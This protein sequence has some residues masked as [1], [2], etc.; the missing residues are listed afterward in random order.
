MRPQ[1][2]AF[3]FQFADQWLKIPVPVKIT[4]KEKRGPDAR[5][6]Q[7]FLNKCPS[8]REFMPGKY[9]RDFFLRGIAT[10]DGTPED[11]LA[12]CSGG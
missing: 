8:L 2:M 6:I 11:R 12:P 3:F 10:D 4:R 9:Q 7:A 1:V 5:I